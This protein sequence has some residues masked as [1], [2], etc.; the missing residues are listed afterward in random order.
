[1]SHSSRIHHTLPFQLTWI[2]SLTYYQILSRFVCSCLSSVSVWHYLWALTH[3]LVVKRY[4]QIDGLDYSDTFST[5]AKMV[6]VCVFMFMAAR[7]HRPL[8]Q[9]DINNVFLHGGLEGDL[10]GATTRF[11]CLEELGIVFK[12]QKSLYGLKLLPRAWFG[13][14]SKVIQQFGMIIT[15]QITMYSSSVYHRINAFILWFMQ[16]LLSL[17]MMT[18]RASRTLSNICSKILKPRT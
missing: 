7:R 18:K 6:S 8:H 12:L 10:Y 16:A 11:C 3:P 4:T 15:R 13:R 2:L 5:V 17:Q 9:L 1:M 14:F